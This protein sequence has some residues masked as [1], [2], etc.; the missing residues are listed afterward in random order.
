M[1]KFYLQDIPQTPAARGQPQAAE[2]P[3]GP[4]RASDTRARYEQLSPLGQRVAP[5]DIAKNIPALMQ[6][7][8]PENLS[9][10]LVGGQLAVGK[11]WGKAADSFSNLAETGIS[12]MVHMR[13]AKDISD[14]ST[15]KNTIELNKAAFEEEVATK[16]LN[17]QEALALAPKYHQQLDADLSSLGLSRANTDQAVVDSKLSKSKQITDLTFAARKEV[18]DSQTAQI[19]ARIKR[20]IANGDIEDALVANDEKLDA[21]L[22]SPGQHEANKNIIKDAYQEQSVSKDIAINPRPVIKELETIEQ[23]GT[24]EIYPNLKNRATVQSLLGQ[25]RQANHSDEV[26]AHQEISDKIKSGEIKNQ[27]DIENVN[28]GRLEQH[29]VDAYVKDIATPAI[30]LNYEAVGDIRAQI[31]G[32]DPKSDPTYQKYNEITQRILTETPKPAA[33]ENNSIREKLTADLA[34]REKDVNANAIKPAQEYWNNLKQEI[35]QQTKDGLIFGDTRTSYNPFAYEYGEGGLQQKEGYGLPKPVGKLKTAEER[36]KVFEREQTAIRGVEEW[37]T[38]HPDATV[39]EIRD[40]W[41]KVVGPEAMKTATE[42]LKE[43][44]RGPASPNAP[45]VAPPS[46]GGYHMGTPAAPTTSSLGGKLSGK[47]DLFAAAGARHGVDP[48]LMMAIAN[49]ETGRGQSDFLKSFNNPGGLMDPATNWSQPQKFATLEQGVDAMAKN[50]KENYIDQGLTTI[51]QIAPK[52][53]PVGAANDPRGVNKDWTA[54]VTKF[55]N[56]GTGQTI[57]VDKR[58]AT[59][60]ASLKPEA[61]GPISSF[62]SRAK[63]WAKEHGFDVV[64]TEGYRSPERQN[65]L[66]AQGRDKNGR[67]IDP[68]KVVTNARGGQSNHQSGRAID[69]AITR[70]GKE[71][72]KKDTWRQLARI[73]KDMGL[74]WGGDFK[75]IY[76]PNHFQ[77]PS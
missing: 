28:A 24:S 66:Y 73:A 33:G 8:L 68:S 60:I 10:A 37:M 39:D 17:A 5:I 49:H 58:S 40:K 59:Q 76:D 44:A 50:L 22:Q 46:Q 15:I 6:Q 63:V 35:H 21:K 51:A 72:D 11:A 53:A 4:Y 12:L 48:N 26:D 77:V 55:Y 42:K 61:Q 31:A 18:N 70:N 74:E 34:K 67:I 3:V 9:N 36:Q 65:E 41:T 43:K 16:N 69:V 62:V 27:T 56:Q 7:G 54:G 23:G 52:Y 57:E 32:Y 64:V 38:N 13:Q 30:P 71:V 75:S 1:A 25:A 20:S 47:E 19:D 2:V 45:S 14:R 29:V